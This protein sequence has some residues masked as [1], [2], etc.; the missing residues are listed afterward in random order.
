MSAVIAIC[1]RQINAFIEAHVHSSVDQC[2]DCLG[3]IINR[4]FYILD[5][6]AVAQIPETVLQILFL[7]RGNILCHMAVEAVADIFSVGYALNNTIL[8]TELLYLQ[9]AQILCGSSVDG[10]QVAVLFLI[11]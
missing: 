2:L 1:Q 7:N 4:I 10:V 6:A 9:T 8:F 11:F 5:L 3:I